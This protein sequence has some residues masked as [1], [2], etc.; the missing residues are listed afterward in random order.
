[1]AR[2]LPVLNQIR[3]FEA[4]A[5]HRSFKAAAEELGVTQS[6]VS[7]QIKA[8]EETLDVRLFTRRTRAVDLGPEAA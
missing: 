3:A 6:A 8:L 1:M 4:A 2:R 5:R 7:H